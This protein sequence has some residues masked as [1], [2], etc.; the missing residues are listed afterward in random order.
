[1]IYAL[2]KTYKLLTESVVMLIMAVNLSLLI[3][4]YSIWNIQ[5]TWSNEMPKEWSTII[6]GTRDLIWNISPVH[7]NIS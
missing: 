3:W 5:F 6:L 7:G 2:N 4:L 1:M